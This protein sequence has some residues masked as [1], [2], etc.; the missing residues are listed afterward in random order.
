MN[1]SVE[2]TS[3]AENDLAKLWNTALDRNA[4]TRASN[5][6]DHHL[7]LDPLRFGEVWTSSVHRIAV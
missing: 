4:V 3:E 5:W 2:W 1:Y 6:L 7:A